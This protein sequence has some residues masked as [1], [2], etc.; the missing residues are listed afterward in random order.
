[1]PE[2][3]KPPTQPEAK[4]EEEKFAE[5]ILK[6]IEKARS[7]TNKRSYNRNGDKQ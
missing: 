5:L 6:L 3:P 7:K 1:M 4:S 2:E